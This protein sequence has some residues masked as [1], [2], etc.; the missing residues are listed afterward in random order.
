MSTLAPK[1]QRQ[2][3]AEA[4]V[5]DFRRDLGP[6]VVAA[7][8][9][10]MPML[11]TDAKAAGNPIIFA[12]DSLVNLTGFTR[13]Q[14]LGRTFGDLM[15][16]DQAREAVEIAFH[17][18]PHDS[19]DARCRSR[20]GEVFWAE[21]F[22]SPV[23]NETGAVIQYFASVFDLTRHRAQEEELRCLL[24]ELN[25]R[26]QNTL[27]TVQALAMQTFRGCPD[28]ALIE[29]FQGRILALSKAHALLARGHWRAVS[30]GDVVDQVLRPFG[31][32]EGGP[33][34]ARGARVMLQPKTALTLAV[35]LHELALNAT[36]HGALI[37][38][39]S[40]RVDLGWTL[41][42]SGAEREMSLFWRE[43]GGPPVQPP[44]RKGFGA[45]LFDR[46]LARE[47]GGAVELD[48]A[49]GGLTCAIVVPVPEAGA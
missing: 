13:E 35:T 2:K 41:R 24:D 47:L 22:V 46:D 36:R 3:R 14:L 19:I 28:K 32:T 4:A 40:G 17:T 7:D 33:L 45:R 5:E 30:L 20:T 48:Y 11:F 27:A 29:A 44:R 37:A 49:P 43:H 39:G 12:N 1:T 8:T 25:H 9:T 34:T 6:F 15:A 10:R 23:R 38:G 26:T 16:D 18:A 21:I 31:A 42:Q